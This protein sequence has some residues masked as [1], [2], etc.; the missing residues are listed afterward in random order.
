MAIMHKSSLYSF[1]ISLTLI[2]SSY[3]APSITNVADPSTDGIDIII[4][5]S[6]FG[7][8][9]A[10]PYKWDN[11]EGGAVGTTVK[12]W[13]TTT[14]TYS[15][16]VSRG[17]GVASKHDFVKNYNVSLNLDDI[18]Y[19]TVYMDFWLYIDLVANE[20]RNF[21]PWRLYGNN[22]K[23]EIFDNDYC[24]RS[25]M[26]QWYDLANSSSAIS[27]KYH[28]SQLSKN[29][30][31][32]HYQ[33]EIV[34]SSVGGADGRVRQYIDGNLDL[35]SAIPATTRYTSAHYNQIRIGHYYAK[36]GDSLC[37]SNP[38]AYVYLDDV[39][40]DTSLARVEI[41]NNP[42]YSKCTHREI[43]IPSKWSST[44]IELG[45]MRGDFSGE[46]PYLFVVDGSGAV[47]NNGSGYSI[48]NIT[49]VPSNDNNTTPEPIP[50][51]LNIKSVN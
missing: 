10:A 22:D 35:V 34:E 47:S 20:S 27:V 30:V 18:A 25:S 28:S 48:S 24:N 2:T 46:N 26:L 50:T 36:D 12:G 13:G 19:T 1:L 51:I 7:T 38:G 45:S 43:Q 16:D 3:A 49:S 29:G 31:W 42:D 40:V 32:K 17:G 6:G 4:E 39:Y 21:K 23:L 14:A 33:V 11:F 15:K 5:G 41:G 8:K 37:P 9:A 44:S